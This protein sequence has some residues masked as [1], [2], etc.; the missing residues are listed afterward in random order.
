MSKATD[1]HRRCG[2]A[3][4]AVSEPF[5]RPPLPRPPFHQH[6]KRSGSMRNIQKH[7][8]EPTMKNKKAYIITPLIFILLIAALTLFIIFGER[9][10]ENPPGTIG[11][12]AGNLNNSG[13]FC[14][15][16]GKVYFANSFDGGHLYSMGVD[17]SNLE[18]LNNSNVCNILAGGEF[19]YYFSL[20]ASGDSGL[21]S[22][23]V[24]KSFNRCKLDGSSVTGLTRDTVI[25]AQLVDNHLYL[26]TGDDATPS[27]DKMKIDKSEQIHLA[28]YIINPACAVNGTIYYNGTQTEHYLHALDTA[29]H[30]SNVVWEGNIWNPIVEGDYVYYMDVANDYRLCRY[31]LSQNVVEVLTDDRVDCFNVGKGY[32][33]YQK[34]GTSPSLN[35]MLTD[36]SNQFVL[37]EGNYTNINITSAFVYFQEFGNDTT[38]YHSYLGSNSVDIFVAA[39]EAAKEELQ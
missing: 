27:F 20:G 34:N 18:K 28:D 19:L 32:I 30:V 23:R 5:N 22:V 2:F 13:L 11:N 24:P 33:Y 12:S 39:R 21:G 1:K 31:S 9:I 36:G 17:E 26:L 3:N 6:A 15:Y 10:P 4:G 37:A 8:G 29:T 7:T 16:N 14:E 25:S 35:C 38:L